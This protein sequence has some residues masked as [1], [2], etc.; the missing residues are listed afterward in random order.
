MYFCKIKTN[1]EMEE[2]L[3]EEFTK[4]LRARGGEV[5]LEVILRLQE[6]PKTGNRPFDEEGKIVGLA[7]IADTIGC[8]KSTAYK[9]VKSGELPHYEVGKKIMCY[10]DELMEHFKKMRKQPC[11]VKKGAFQC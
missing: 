10:Q 8:S 7:A 6:M 4:V 5:K 2:K 11:Y 1:K 3:I 9:L